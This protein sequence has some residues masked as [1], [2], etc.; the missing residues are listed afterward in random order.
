MGRRGHGEGSVYR[1]SRDG[2]WVGSVELGRGPDGERIRRTVVR[3]SKRAVLDRLDEL[4]RQAAQGVAPDNARTVAQY[5]DWWG[6]NVLPGSVKDSTVDDYRY[7]IA[8]YVTPHVGRHRLAKLTPEHVQAMM[9]ALEEAGYSSRTRQYARAVLRR[10][11]RWA[12][13]TGL[14][15]RNAAALVDG[16]KKSGTKL[17]DTLTAAEA[18]AVLDAASGDRLGAL[19][20]LSLGLRKGEALALGWPDIDLD[21][22]ELIVRGTLKRRKGG[23]LYLDTPKTAAGWRRVPLVGGTVEALREHYRRQLAETARLPG[24]AWLGACVRQHDRWSARCAERDS[25][26]AQPAQPGGCRAAPFSGDTPHGGDVAARRGRA[27]RSGLSDPRPCRAGDHSG[28]VCQGDGRLD[29]S[30]A[31]QTRQRA[32]PPV[33]VSLGRA[34]AAPTSS[35]LPLALVDVY[36]GSTDRG[37]RS[38]TLVT[39]RPVAR[40]ERSGVAPAPAGGLERAR[41][42]GLGDAVPDRRARA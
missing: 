6:M 30:V 9:R 11:L 38:Y 17:D 28:R 19:A 40:H 12:E 27:A 41:G 23:G 39:S 34:A 31:R 32:R 22:G 25:M 4:R 14:V 26:V 8:T 35:H 13:Q 37:R 15:A 3:A 16:P 21:V 36:A 10:A 29:A 18:R 20:V 7:I 1:R 24:L 2:K 42:D 33:K 5:L